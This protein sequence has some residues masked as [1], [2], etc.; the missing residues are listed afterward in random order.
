MKK[1]LLALCLTMN[2]ISLN[3]CAEHTE[4]PTIEAVFVGQPLKLI[5][6]QGQCTLVKPDQSRTKLDM[7]WPCSFSLDEHQKLRVETFN[8]IPIFSVW[9]VEHMPAPSRDCLNKMQAIRQIQ[10]HL[11]V[12]PVS[13]S[14]SCGWGGDQKMYIAPFTW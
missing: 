5:D 3:A 6:D 8:G 9:R 10:G 4:M 1:P 2:V 13:L 14:A 11:E 7:E 12:G